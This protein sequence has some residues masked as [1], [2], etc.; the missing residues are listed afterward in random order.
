MSD[1]PPKTL[2]SRFQA[3]SYLQP[4]EPPRTRQKRYPEEAAGARG[5]RGGRKNRFSSPNPAE[6]AVQNRSIGTLAV[7]AQARY[8]L[9]SVQCT[10]SAPGRDLF[11]TFT[12][13]GRPRALYGPNSLGLGDSPKS[14]IFW[15]IRLPS[16]AFFRR[17]GMCTATGPH[18]MIFAMMKDRPIV[19]RNRN[20]TGGTAVFHGTKVPVQSPLDYRE[21]GES[22]DNF[23]EGT[24]SAARTHVAFLEEAKDRVV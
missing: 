19:S 6:Q 16:V 17:Q 20:V 12:R 2:S 1:G 9:A 21:A 3:L 14:S 7:R 8:R 10:K 22:I 23:L 11:N 15:R 18:D 4:A 24:P 5:P 13:A